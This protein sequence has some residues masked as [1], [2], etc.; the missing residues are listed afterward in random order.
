MDPESKEKSYLRYKTKQ[1]HRIIIDDLSSIPDVK[2]WA[3]EA[4]VSRRWLCKAMKK[5]HGTSPKELLRER[6]Y[7]VLVK[8]LTEDPDL[9][10]YCLAREVGL[11]D[12]KSLYKFL[13]S[14]YDTNLTQLRDEIIAMSTNN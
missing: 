12:E 8:C 9:T 6:R 3:N 11:S 2:T 5:E 10:G 1:A 14:H 7:V 4:G 13:T